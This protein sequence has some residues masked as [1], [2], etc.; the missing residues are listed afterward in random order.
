[1]AAIDGGNGVRR[2]EGHGLAARRV[3]DQRLAG[4]QV[5]QIEP[6]RPDEIGR[7]RAVAQERYVEFG[8]PVF[9]QQHMDQG[10]HEGRIGLRADRHPFGRTGASD[11][12]VRLDM[13][14]LVAAHPCIGVPGDGAGPAG[15]LDIGTERNDVAC[16][17][18]VGGDGEGA[19]PE[20]AVEM[21]GVDA[22]DALTRAETVIDWSPGREKSRE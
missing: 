9:M 22:F 15:H 16:V 1:M 13:H 18:R 3:P 10:E 20:L 21:F 6:V 4:D 17:G 5:A 11:G 8:E 7:G 14:A 2:I 12:K 19:V